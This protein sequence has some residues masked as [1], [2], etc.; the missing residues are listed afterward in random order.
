LLEWF[1]TWLK[2]PSVRLL[3]KSLM[4]QAIGAA[5]S[6]RA[7]PGRSLEGGFLAI[8]NCGRASAAD[9]RRP[10][11]ELPVPWQ[12]WR[13]SNRGNPLH[14]DDDLH[15]ARC[16]AFRKRCAV[17]QRRQKISDALAETY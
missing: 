11:Q 16:R 2:E 5:R 14:R 4:G 9:G 8:N 17:S 7:E 13:G 15:V 10:P 12:L 3:P 1:G 6:S